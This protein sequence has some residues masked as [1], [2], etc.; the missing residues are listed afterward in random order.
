VLLI[1]FFCIKV[2][3][4]IFIII[5]FVYCILCTLIFENF[6][7]GGCL[8][9]LVTILLFFNI[10]DF[11]INTNKEKLIKVLSIFSLIIC[12]IY[13]FPYGKNYGWYL[14]NK[15][16]PNTWGVLTAFSFIIWSILVDF[17]LFKNKFL[18]ILLLIITLITIYNFK[19]RGSLIAVLVYFCLI[20]LPKKIFK[21]KMIYALLI[22][23]I[24]LGTFFPIIYLKL[25]ESGVNL[26]IFGKSL[27]TGRETIW[28]EMF[29]KFKEDPFSV[30][31]GLG[32]KTS[33]SSEYFISTHN[34]YFQLILN[35]GIIGY[36]IFWIYLFY[37]LKSLIKNVSNYN[38]LKC[39]FAFISFILIL[40]F[41]ES[42]ILVDFL[43]IPM[44]FILGVGFGKNKKLKDIKKYDSKN[45]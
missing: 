43:C 9:F 17:K 2:L 39:I 14:N 40:G 32:S 10:K 7:I 30:I 25:Y 16:N 45:N 21:T 15:I 22:L 18:F 3:E 1:L 24:I 20:I 36:V 23:I 5:S 31:F 19:A 4:L 6:G 29:L 41:V 35:F 38:I 12:L 26:E 11:N 37:V 28:L 44:F 27:Y 8:N 33:L 34:S 42:T 13:S